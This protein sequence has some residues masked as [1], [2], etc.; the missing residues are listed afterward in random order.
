MSCVALSALTLPHASSGLP[1]KTSSRRSLRAESH[2]CTA[3]AAAESLPRLVLH[4]SLD[5]A[6][7]ETKLAR[8]A[9]EGFVKQIQRLS[10]IGGE[11]SIVVRVGADLARASLQ[12]AAEDDSLISHSSVPLPVDSFIERLDDLSMEFCSLYMPPLKS[13]PEVFIGNLERYFYVHKGFHRAD[14]M[15]DARSLY[16]HSA[17]TCRSGSAGILSLIYSE[18]I[19]MLRVY[20]FL[21]FDVEVHFPHDLSSLPRGYQKQ[22]SQSSDQ[23]HIITTKSLLVKILRDL[24]DTFWPFQYDR[25]TSLFIRA[26]HAANL[27]F[28][29]RTVGERHY[30]SRGSASGFEI[31]SSK[32]AHH[33]IERGV[34]T[35]ARF[36]DM[37]RALAACERLVLLDAGHEELRDYAI[38]LYHC[39]F[40][41]VCLQFL[42][43]YQSTKDS[44]CNSGPDKMKELEEDLT[45]NLMARVNL[46]LGE[47]GWS[48]SDVSTKYWGRSPE[49]W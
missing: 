8:D 29:S 10:R 15:S 2:S 48:K 42:K 18:I 7:V 49:P 25:A 39:G 45:L 33:R 9:R 13:P 47:E 32:A 4:D 5:E 6:G 38:L 31:A 23:S 20:G 34:W 36:G 35:I 3:S 40:Y 26:A 14:A 1:R 27:T 19:K 21:E 12:I 16:L 28:G 17:L 11:A 37:R 24:K 41:E 44:C 43:L 22:K 30:N 46:I